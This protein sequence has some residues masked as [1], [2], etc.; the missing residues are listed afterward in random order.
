MAD[1]KLPLKPSERAALRRLALLER[2][3]LGDQAAVIVVRE[4]ERRG[5]LGTVAEAAPNG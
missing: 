4:L 2:R 1:I 3:E 5:L